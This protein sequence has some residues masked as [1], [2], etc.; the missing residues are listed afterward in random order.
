MRH[1]EQP[2]VGAHRVV[3]VELGAVMQRHVPTAEVDD[4]GAFANM[5][6]YSGV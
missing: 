5:V 1:V 3:L 2:R 6:S 4:L